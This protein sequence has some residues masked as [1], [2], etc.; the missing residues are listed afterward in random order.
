[1]KAEIMEVGIIIQT[2]Q[3][4]TV[5]KGITKLLLDKKLPIYQPEML[6]TLVQQV[7]V[8]TSKIMEVI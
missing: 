1:M 4:K 5:K 3:R 8:L 6:E 7:R 2:E